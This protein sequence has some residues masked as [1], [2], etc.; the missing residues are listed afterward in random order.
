[1]KI[2][3]K[4]FTGFLKKARMEGGQQINECIF[5]FEKDGLKIK[6][7]SPTQQARTSSWLK[8]SAFKEY[9]AIGKVGVNDLA[10]VVRVLERFG[11]IIEVKVEGNLMTIKSGNKKVDIELVAENFLSTD[12]KEPDLSFEDTF[13]IPASKIAEIIKDVELN[14]DAVITIETEEKQVKFS[15]TG[16]YKF[17]HT[18][19]APTVK[20]GA[21]V[22]VG[23][24]FVSAVRNLDS[25]LEMS[26]KS[27]YPVKIMEKLETSVITLIVA[28]RVN[29]EEK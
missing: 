3:T 10:N 13:V 7:N 17:V 2:K 19:A 15:N 27:N 28:P 9:E 6:V 8:T 4:V 16:K 18:I 21:K 11:E 1:M 26:I 23:E 14:K 29:D 24:P 12:I 20:G 25:N 5:H 22:N